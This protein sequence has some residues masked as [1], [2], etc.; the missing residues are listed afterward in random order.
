MPLQ[1]NAQGVLTG[2]FTVPKNVPSGT[3]LVEFFGKGGSSGAATYTGATSV[4]VQR[5]LTVRV[6]PRF[7]DP[8]AQTFT[9][10]AN[11]HITSIDLRVRALGN[12]AN[13]ISV[14]IRGTENGVP[15]QEILADAER[16]ATELNTTAPWH[17]WTFGTPVYLKADTEYAIVVLTDDPIHALAIAQLGKADPSTGRWITTQPYTVGVLLSSSNA[18]TW[19]PHQ[20]MDLTF[21]I[22]AAQFSATTRVLDLG[23]IELDGASDLAAIAPIDRPSNATNVVMRYTLANGTQIDLQPGQNIPFDGRVSG[24]VTAQAILTGSALESPVFFQ[25][26]QTAVGDLIESANYFTR[27]VTVGTSKTI[28]VTF[29]AL[30]PGSSAVVP[31]YEGATAGQYTALSSPEAQPVGDGWVEYTYASPTVT[32]DTTRVRLVLNGTTAARPRVRKL[33][34]VV[35]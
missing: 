1:A 9:L 27:A 3:K 14:Q 21:R 35:V 7:Y 6:R 15:T 26:A 5:W 17:R 28:K 11:R 23:T 18:S 24:E 19:T 32:Q 31:A 8:L 2:T 10:P 25:G 22:N 16:E 33:K 13:P 34:V 29:E 30:T 4:L 20:D 12:T